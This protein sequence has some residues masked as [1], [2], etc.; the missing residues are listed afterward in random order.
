M[1]EAYYIEEADRMLNEGTDLVEVLEAMHYM[2][3]ADQVQDAVYDKVS[4]H[5]L[6]E[7]LDIDKFIKV[8]ECK[9]IDNPVFFTRDNTPT[10]TGLLSNEIFGVTFSDRSGIFA[11]IDLATYFID[12]S[13]CKA[14]FNTDPMVKRIIHKDGKFIINARGYFEENDSG[15][16]GLDWL[17]KNIS[18]V[19]F[20][21]SDRESIKR[22]IRVRY[23]EL[24]R[25]RMF[26]NKFLV[27][28]PFYRDTNSAS[29]RKGTVGVGKIN[30]LYQQL[31]V[32]ANMIR[33]TEEF[34]F[35]MSGPTQG[36][37]QEVLIAIYDWFC[38]TNNA[39][40]NKDEEGTGISG[41]FGVLRRANMSK[42]S[43]YAA[44]LVISA[45]ELK[46]HKKDE[47]MVNF[48]YSALPLSAAIACFA[49]FIQYHVR[50]F[51]ENEFVG[52]EQYATVD[53]SGKVV[54]KIP[55]DPL[56]E[57]SDDRIK[58]EMERFIH[59]YNNRIIPIKVPMED[60]SKAYMVFK[61]TYQSAGN[62]EIKETITTRRLTWLDVL[63]QA[64]CEVA[65]DHMVLITRFPVDSRTNQITTKF[66]VSSLIDTEPMYIGT[67]YYP[68]YPK[69]QEK[70]FGKDTSNMFIDTLQFSNLYLAGLGGDFDGDQC[71]VRGVFTDEANVELASFMNTKKNFIG[72]G[73]SNLRN[74]GADAIQSLYSLTKVLDK[75]KSKLTKNISF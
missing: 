48:D 5:L 66:N 26:I 61:G 8:N 57:F 50:R 47:M 33:S 40:I 68:Y 36:R 16:N 59:G 24:N 75:D 25:N 22:D 65:K 62:Q 13:C 2:M 53:S 10:S 63:Y 4:N 7:V 17:R 32:S 12:P 56:I 15:N 30:K 51:F 9:E 39:S 1:Q 73:G 34:G 52:T 23:L 20:K 45:P 74:V 71:T 3:E 27:I 49:P 29:S 60:G 41:K 72:L 11:Y 43:N 37:T 69:I 58:T 64:A 21:S 6:V 19:K 70:D 44:R 18:K 46:A 14:W 67:T 54:Y 42:T 35:D 28:P 38:G 31:I 55:K